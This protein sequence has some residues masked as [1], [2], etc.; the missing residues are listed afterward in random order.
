[1]SREALKKK[2]EQCVNDWYAKMQ[3]VLERFDEHAPAKS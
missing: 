3:E 2:L 1:V